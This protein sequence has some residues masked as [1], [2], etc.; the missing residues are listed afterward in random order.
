[1]SRRSAAPRRYKR[2]QN[3]SA[4]SAGDAAHLA[5]P[6]PGSQ[7]SVVV[8]LTTASVAHRAAR[9]PDC[10]RHSAPPNPQAKDFAPQDSVAAAG[11]VQPRSNPALARRVLQSTLAQVWTATLA[12]RARNPTML[13]G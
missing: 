3:H 10:L 4:E 12:S 5:K 8:V 11:F 7:L 9:I 2:S 13:H 1:M 6:P